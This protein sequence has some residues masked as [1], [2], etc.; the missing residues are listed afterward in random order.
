MSAVPQERL[1][2]ETTFGLLARL[3]DCGIGESAERHADNR[4]GG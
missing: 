4:Y 3:F 2:R 1:Y